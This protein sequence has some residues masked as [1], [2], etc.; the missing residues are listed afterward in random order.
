V[1]TVVH[2][3]LQKS[4]QDANEAIERIA[5]IRVLPTPTIKHRAEMQ[6]L[7]KKLERMQAKVRLLDE[8]VDDEYVP[9]TDEIIENLDTIMARVSALI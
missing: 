5:N 1:G 6:A 8:I 2:D 9:V 4:A 7:Y 3:K